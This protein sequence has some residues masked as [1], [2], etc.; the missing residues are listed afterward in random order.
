MGSGK[1]SSNMCYNK[2]HNNLFRLVHTPF[3]VRRMGSG[4]LTSYKND[5]EYDNDDED[6]DE[7][8]LLI[9]RARVHDVVP[10][11]RVTSLTVLAGWF[12]GRGA[13]VMHQLRHQFRG[14]R[15]RL[16]RARVHG[17]PAGHLHRERGHPR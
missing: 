16:L 7:E 6:D 2:F 11:C 8:G 5:D 1:L 12:Q 17:A 9:L 13:D 15:R 10:P 14:W 3:C 4:K